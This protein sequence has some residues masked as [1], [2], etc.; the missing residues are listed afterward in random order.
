MSNG[1]LPPPSDDKWERR[2]FYLFQCLITIWILIQSTK[3]NTDVQQVN[4]NVEVV[5]NKVEQK[6]TEIVTKQDTAATKI[7]EKAEVD[8][9]AMGVQLYSTWKYLQDV[10]TDSGNP[11][12]K[13]EADKARKLYEEFIRKH[14]GKSP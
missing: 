5:D 3:N 13:E 14:N 7:T 4:R 1:N 10:A 11:K 12:D 8:A 2:A 6:A 9:K